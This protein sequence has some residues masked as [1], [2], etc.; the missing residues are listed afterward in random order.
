MK[1]KNWLAC[2]QDRGKWI[3]VVEKAKTFNQRKFSAWKKKEGRTG[4]SKTKMG[5]YLG[6]EGTVASCASGFHTNS[7]AHVRERTSYRFL[8]GKYSKG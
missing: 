1:I 5:G 6:A 8:V 3:E 2:V 4:I 7:K